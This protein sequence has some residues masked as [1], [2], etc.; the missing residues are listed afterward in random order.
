[1][2][3]K[4]RARERR[5]QKLNA[6]AAVHVLG[7]CGLA[8]SALS[9]AAGFFAVP[10]LLGLAGVVMTAANLYALTTGVVAQETQ[11]LQETRNPSGSARTE[12]PSD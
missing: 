6:L 4:D 8:A 3:K 11:A 12:A 5:P 2:K 10:S 1:M 7:A 9:S